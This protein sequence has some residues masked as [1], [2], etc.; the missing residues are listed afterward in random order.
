MKEDLCDDGEELT[1]ILR[2][3][4]INEGRFTRVDRT[5][6]AF[7][8]GCENPR[9]RCMLAGFQERSSIDHS[10]FVIEL[11][12]ELVQ[13]DIVPILAGVRST[14]HIVPSHNDGAQSRASFAQANDITFLPDPVAL[15]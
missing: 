9:P 15:V 5:T 2:S 6:Q 1:A 3:V 13:H 11:M 10:I 14:R 7:I 4:G 8:L 12:C